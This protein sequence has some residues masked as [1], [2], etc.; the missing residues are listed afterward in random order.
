MEESRHVLQGK[1]KHGNVP[2]LISINLPLALFLPTL[3]DEK[4]VP[5]DRC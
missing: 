1:G 3:Y 2:W 4:A 5:L